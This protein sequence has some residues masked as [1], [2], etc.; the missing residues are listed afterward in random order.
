[1]SY[2]GKTTTCRWRGSYWK[3]LFIRASDR[4]GS[5]VWRGANM[6]IAMPRSATHEPRRSQRV[7]RTPSTIQSQHTAV[8][9]LPRLSMR[10]GD[11]FFLNFF[12]R[13]ERGSFPPA[14]TPLPP[15]LGCALR[16]LSRWPTSTTWV[17]SL[18]PL[19]DTP[20]PGPAIVRFHGG[21]ANVSSKLGKGSHFS[22]GF[23]LGKSP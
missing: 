21:A 7:G 5:Q 20:G 23:P 15:T 2:S 4:K 1:M 18:S 10:H 19:P 8:N 12:I 14:V 6:M 16:S 17:V 11:S 22:I 9:V 3:T 13:I